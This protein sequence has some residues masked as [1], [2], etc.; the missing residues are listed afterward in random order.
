MTQEHPI[1]PSPELV[2]K[3][4]AMLEYCEDTDVFSDIARWGAD[5]EVEACCQWLA[6][7]GYD[8]VAAKF[9]S[10]RRPKPPSVKDQALQALNR[11]M[12][13]EGHEGCTDEDLEEDY[14]FIRKAVESLPD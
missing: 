13:T 3:W 5:Q 9:R 2:E 12:A 7:N 8:L 1:T 14:Y 4:V 11:F 6:L 10:A